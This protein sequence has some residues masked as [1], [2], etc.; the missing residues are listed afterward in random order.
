MAD[1]LSDRIRMEVGEN[2]EAQVDRAFELCFG[3]SPELDEAPGCREF[4]S[5]HG[6]PALA[7]VLFNA[8]EFVY[9]D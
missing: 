1:A 9:V 5:R 4:V 7:R 8:N 2:A 6:L 3:R